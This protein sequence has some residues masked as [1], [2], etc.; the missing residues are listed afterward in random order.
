MVSYTTDLDVIRSALKASDALDLDE[1]GDNLRRRFVTP[2]KDPHKERIVHAS[3]FGVDGGKDAVETN[4]GKALERFGSVQRTCALRNLSQDGR[5][6]DGSAFVRFEKAE[7]AQS[8]VEMSG[9]VISGRKIGLMASVDWFTRLEKKRA[10]MKRK[11]DEKGKRPPQPKKE[12]VP[13]CVLKFEKLESVPECS[14]E[15]LRSVCEKAGGAVK[16]VEFS[17]GDA[18][19]H[20]RLGAP[21]ILEKRPRAV[22]QGYEGHCWCSTATPEA[23]TTRASRRRPPLLGREVADGGRR[24]KGQAPAQ[25]NGHSA[26]GRYHRAAWAR[27]RALRVIRFSKL[28]AGGRRAS[29]P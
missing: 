7:D 8:A 16:Y 18:V 6:L 29:S 14:R 21:G 12:N 17:R 22:H 10:S 28:S 25:C 5:L 1:Q 2:D 23:T 15:D 9:C 20:V 4:I 24:A 13:G 26:S 19:G 11:R 27:Q 3:G